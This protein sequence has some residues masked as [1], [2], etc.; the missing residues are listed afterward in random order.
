MTRGG[1]AN[2]ASAWTHRDAILQLLRFGYT[3]RLP[4]ILYY[5]QCNM[6]QAMVRVQDDL[7]H[8]A[9]KHLVNHFEERF[10]V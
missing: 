4:L 8:H 5:V 9:A 1:P 2:R 3:Q 6:Q 7:M 10:S